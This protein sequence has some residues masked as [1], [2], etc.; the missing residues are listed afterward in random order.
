[1]QTSNAVGAAASQLGPDA[2]A[3]MVILNKDLGLSHGK[4][5]AGRA[6]GTRRM[7][8]RYARPVCLYVQFNRR[9]FGGGNLH[10]GSREEVF[11]SGEA[12][13]LAA[14]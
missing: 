3:A 1:L 5:A 8:R 12:R 13:P 14:D 6:S 7:Q 10:W 4:V 9:F 2:H 11:R